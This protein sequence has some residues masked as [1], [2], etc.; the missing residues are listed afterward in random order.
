[1]QPSR[2]SPEPS[3]SWGGGY[4]AQLRSW[5]IMKLDAALR[6]IRAHGMAFPAVERRAETTNTI[7]I[8]K[9]G[10]I[11]LS[12]VCRLHRSRTQ[13][14]LTQISRPAHSLSNDSSVASEMSASDND[15]GRHNMPQDKWVRKQL[16][17]IKRRFRN[18]TL[19]STRDRGD[20]ATMDA[21]LSTSRRG[22]NSAD[23]A[24]A[25]RRVVPPN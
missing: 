11:F 14:K 8:S 12:K 3:P 19:T 21:R 15:D 5:L 6:D 22:R 18:E 7:D 24:G 13:T 9:D 17:P 2:P 10:G 1:M 20:L 23:C 16:V 4:S 25:G